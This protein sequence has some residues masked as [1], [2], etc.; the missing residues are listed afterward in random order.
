[1]A[2]EDDD[3]EK[4]NRAS[5]NG[6]LD[7]PRKVRHNFFGILA[8]SRIEGSR[9]LIAFNRISFFLFPFSCDLALILDSVS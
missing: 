7:S 6:H 4:L 8:C 1:V 3:N 9:L 2:S 5:S